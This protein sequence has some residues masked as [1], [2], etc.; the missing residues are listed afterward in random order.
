MNNRLSKL[1]FLTGVG[2]ALTLGLRLMAREKARMDFMGK[3]V[4]ITGGSRGLGLVIARQL[5]QE[6]ARLALLARDEEELMR[7]REELEQMDAEA[8]YLVCDLSNKDQVE[9]TL[10]RV[11]RRYGQ[12]D[13][14][15]NNA[16]I[17]QVGPYEH[18]TLEDFEEAMSIHFWGALYA[19]MEAINYMRQQGGGRIVNITSIGGKV[20]VPHLLPYVA[21]KYALTGLSDGLRAELAKENILV[22]TVIPGLMRTGSHVNAL[23]KGRHEQEYTWFSVF[24]ALPIS[25][26]EATKAAR[27]IIEAC[28]FGQAE[29]VITWQARLLLLANTLT[30]GLVAGVMKMAARLLPEEDPERGDEIKAGWESLSRLSPSA[31]TA[32]SDQAVAENNQL[33]DPSLVLGESDPEISE[34]RP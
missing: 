33:E 12:I 14:L 10:S 13:V 28:R 7:A 6:G 25:S 8:M 16:G 21:S 9:Y 32:L 15:I 5:A 18:M 23:F 31:L 2:L 34:A 27:Q 20:A 26:T 11:V 30:P 4:V 24:G 17:I 22:T 3:V 1:S 29:L 19:S